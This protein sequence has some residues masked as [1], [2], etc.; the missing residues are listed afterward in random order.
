MVRLHL[1]PALG[2]TRLD[3]L[4]AL[5]LQSLY[6]SKLDSGLSARTVRMIHTTLHKALKQAVKWSLIPR[7]V[8]E[9]V[10]PPREQKTEISPLNEGEVR[11]LL[12]AVRGDKLEALYVLAITTGMRSGELLGLR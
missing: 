3:R 7:N 11:K 5:Q 4:N 1:V 6:S 10:D 8:T 12:E 2:T 9:A